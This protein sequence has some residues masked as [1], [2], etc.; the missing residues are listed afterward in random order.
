[1]FRQSVK[2]SGIIP[3]ATTFLNIN[4]LY[5]IKFVLI[6]ILA[7]LKINHHPITNQVT[8]AITIAVITAI[9]VAVEATQNISLQVVRNDDMMIVLIAILQKNTSN[10]C[11]ITHLIIKF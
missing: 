3:D 4:I 10:F 1:M 11:F 8:A 6:I 7:H 9:V 2:C 5:E